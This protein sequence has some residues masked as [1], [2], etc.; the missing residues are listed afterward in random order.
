MVAP[1]WADA[2]KEDSMKTIVCS[3]LFAVAVASCA[4]PASPPQGDTAQFRA[5]LENPI[6][7]DRDRG[8]DATRHPA[9]LLEFAQVRPGMHVL[10]MV[11]GAGYTSQILA[12]AVG[13]S[14]KVWAQ[15]PKPGATLSERMTAHPQA[16]L[17]VGRGRSTIRCRPR[18]LPWTW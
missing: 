6:R 12:L 15:A 11:A 13:P 2:R 18:P 1:T 5:L 9:E 10:D 7:T 14:G 16:N 4:G 3:V 8:M 17:V